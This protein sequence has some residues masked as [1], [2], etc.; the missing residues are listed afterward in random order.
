MKKFFTAR[1]VAIEWLFIMASLI[2]IILIAVID[3]GFS[4]GI[5]GFTRHIDEVPLVM[6]VFYSISVGVRLTI[7]SIK[8]L[9]SKD[10]EKISGS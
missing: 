8:T 10:N 4:A 3:S 6:M 5:A 1:R 2:A 7:W 9:L